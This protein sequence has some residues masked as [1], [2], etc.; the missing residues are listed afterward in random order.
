MSR[1]SKPLPSS[2]TLSA[3]A[4]PRPVIVTGP[5]GVG[6]SAFA[7]ALAERVGGEIIGADAFQLY[8]GLSV[9][10]AQP[11]DDLQSCVPHHLSGVLD[12]ESRYDAAAFLRDAG[13][14]VSD[15]QRRGK[16]PILAGGTG[17]YLKAF[18]HG[19]AELPL[20]DSALRLEIASLSIA[21]VLRRL[22]ALDGA[23]VTE[24]DTCNPVRVRRALEIVLQTGKPLADSRKQWGRVPSSICG[25]VLL[26]DRG[27]LRSRISANVDAMFAANVS[28]EVAAAR[29]A[30]P[31]PRRA[32]GFREIEAFLD[33]RMDEAACR[34]AIVLAT[35]K[36]AKRQMTWCRTQFGFPSLE[37]TEENFPGSALDKAVGLLK[38]GGVMG[39]SD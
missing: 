37:L 12:L 35:W 6:K 13:S 24:I 26:R 19:L 2:N 5:T 23:A 25:V 32:I 30:G 1:S 8:R 16:I 29:L 15:I 39:H 27:E 7:C 10:T 17:L 33:G 38:I 21:E 28:D 4:G 11:G 18:T 31:G 34:E 36:Y 3:P 14:L 9:L 20:P 22:E